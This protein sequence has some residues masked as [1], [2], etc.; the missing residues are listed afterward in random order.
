MLC[1][2][3]KSWAHDWCGMEL[4]LFIPVPE[5][6][7]ANEKMIEDL[8]HQAEDSAERNQSQLKEKGQM[9]QVH[10]KYIIAGFRLSSRL[11]DLFCSIRIGRPFIA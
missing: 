10:I 5:Q 6:A 11:V 8:K 2:S 3:M 4:M 9:M 1:E 7:H